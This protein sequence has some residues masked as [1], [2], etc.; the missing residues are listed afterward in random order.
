MIQFLRLTILVFLLTGCSS[1]HVANNSTQQP[2]YESPQLTSVQTATNDDE[3]PTSNVTP[4]TEP[5]NDETIKNTLF[6]P[7]FKSISELM[8]L[9]KNQIIEKL[10]TDYTDGSGEGTEFGEGLF[11]EQYG[12]FIT[13]GMFSK[14]GI[15]DTIYCRDNVDIKGAKLGMTFAEIQQVLG[16]GDLTN[17][18]YISSSNFGLSYYLDNLAIWFG[19]DEEDGVTSKLEITVSYYGSEDPVYPIYTQGFSDIE[20]IMSLN[21]EQVVAK[22][23]SEYSLYYGNDGDTHLGEGLYYAQYGMVIIFDYDQQPAKVEYIFCQDNVDIKGAKMGMT[24]KEIQKILGKGELLD[25]SDMP[26]GIAYPPFYILTY[27]FGEFT[28]RFGADEKDGVTTE[29][30]IRRRY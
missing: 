17:E 2:A 6:T 14:A 7:D 9:K 20:D 15:I 4:P 22:F 11:Y 29:L 1:G 23:G 5:N 3:S 26:W 18:P 13:F 19:A 16:E 21:E 12:L 27:E 24:F 28:V 25:F 30:D 8:K 10:G